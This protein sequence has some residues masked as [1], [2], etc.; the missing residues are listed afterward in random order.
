MLKK[1]NSYLTTSLLQCFFDGNK[2]REGLAHLLSFNVQVFSVQKVINSL[3]AFVKGSRL[4]NLIVVVGKRQVNATQSAHQLDQ[5]QWKKPLQSI[6]CASQ[7]G[8]FPRVNL[9]LALQAWNASRGQDLWENALL[10]VCPRVNLRLPP[11]ALST[12]AA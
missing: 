9:T 10:Q 12:K 8:L 7:N 11:F 3:V 4:C 6:Q 5:E 1:H 2:V